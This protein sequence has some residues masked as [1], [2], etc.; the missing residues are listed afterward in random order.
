MARTGATAR[1]K[2]KAKALDLLDAAQ[3]SDGLRFTDDELDVLKKISNGTYV[4]NATA[5]LRAI[6][7]RAG[8]AYG[9]P[10]DKIEH[11]GEVTHAIRIERIG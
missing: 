11:S 3:F 4:R 2:H 1:P 5:V 9:K 10:K 8:Y 7:L 6:E